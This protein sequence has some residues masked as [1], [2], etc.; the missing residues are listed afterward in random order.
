MVLLDNG[1]RPSHE[2]ALAAAPLDLAPLVEHTW[3]QQGP[4]PAPTWRVVADPAPHLI[5]A[6]TSRAGVK[7]LRVALVGARSYAADIDV[8][9]RTL[10]VGVRL[11]PGALPALTD[12]AAHTM[13]NWSVPID[14]VFAASQL[15]DL[16]IGSDAPADVLAGELLRLIRRAARGRAPSRQ[17]P[18]AA[19][20]SCRVHDFAA[21]LATPTRSLREA[22]RRDV[23]LAPKRLL[24]ILRLHA[25]LR[26]M[27]VP[28]ASWAQAAAAAGYAD[29]PH[30]TR[31][32]G[33]LLG[34][35][36]SRWAARGAAVSF[37]T[38]IAA[39]R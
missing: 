19:A 3:I 4:H 25:A 16:Q 30:L 11:R 21:R 20:R 10:T 27:R 15:A 28:G 18:E 22:V 26:A 5:A 7:A 9:R 2:I 39:A 29:Q 31:E 8:S 24:R 35:T 12:A 23:G 1:G 13:A 37:K 32:V 34:E 14:Q 33:T 6:V 17:L 38:A 36:P